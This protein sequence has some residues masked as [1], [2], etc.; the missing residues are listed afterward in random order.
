M[1]NPALLLVLLAA[2]GWVA[3]QWQADRV[4]ARASGAPQPGAFPGATDAP[5]R[6][7]V[8]AIAGALGL[9]ALETAGEFALGI[10]REQSR[11][12]WLFAAYSVLSAPV[13]EELVFRGW[14]VVAHRGRALLGM[15]VVAASALFALLH[16]F[17]WR[18][19]DAGL[20][21]TLTTKGA[22]ST[23]ML[24]AGSLWFYVARFAPWNPQRSLLPCFAAHAAKN[25]GVVA[26][27]LALGFVG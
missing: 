11:L 26:V 18:W 10:A 22:F 24:F 20:A 15:S 23:A 6:A 16:P 21:L 9:L 8:I 13:I 19:D 7:T 17:L 27:K 4:A 2:G 25:A 1:Q 3:W 5:A 14:I 12:T